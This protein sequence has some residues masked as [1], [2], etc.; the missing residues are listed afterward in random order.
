MQTLR[1]TINAEEARH[2]QK[3]RAYNVLTVVTGCASFIMV[4]LLLR[5]EFFPSPNTRAIEVPTL[6]SKWQNCARVGTRIG[7]PDASVSILVFSDLECPFCRRLHQAVDSMIREDSAGLSMTLVH[8]P[9]SGHRFAL[10]TARAAECAREQGKFA[11]MLSVLFTSQDS[12]G[13][14]GWGTLANRAGVPDTSQLVGCQRSDRKLAAIEKGQSATVEAKVS[15]TP[16]VII[17][18][19]RFATPPSTDTIGAIV[20]RVKANRPVY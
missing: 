15:G 9:I 2:S 16:T 14:L 13:L 19:W 4:G 5:R 20:Q 17:N 8:S 11:Q 12:L 3:E 6:D 10:P 7:R 18:G 1:R